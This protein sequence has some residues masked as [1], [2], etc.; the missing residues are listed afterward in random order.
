VT[1]T[2]TVLWARRSRH[3]LGV[4]EVLVTEVFLPAIAG[5]EQGGRWP[6]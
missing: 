3:R 1:P 5:L 4:Q 2:G 6:G